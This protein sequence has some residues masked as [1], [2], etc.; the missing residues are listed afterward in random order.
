[1]SILTLEPHRNSV[2]HMFKHKNI[3]NLELFVFFFFCI[4]MPIR[5]DSKCHSIHGLLICHKGCQ[6]FWSGLYPQQIKNVIYREMDICVMY[7]LEAE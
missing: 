7:D 2:V 1:M 4:K 3:I 5:L 6:Y